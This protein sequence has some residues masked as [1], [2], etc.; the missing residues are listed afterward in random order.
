MHL[1]SNKL[2]SKVCKKNCLSFL[3][4]LYKAQRKL[5]STFLCSFFAIFPS[6]IMQRISVFILQTGLFWKK[7]VYKLLVFFNWV[8]YMQ[9][10]HMIPGVNIIGG[11]LSIVSINRA[12][13]SVGVLRPQQ[14]FRGAQL[15]K[16]IFRL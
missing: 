7:N 11:K 16:K 1:C 12:G 6:L 14:S 8:P 15:P 4:T 2:A 9:L 3:Y 10:S 13:R 5:E